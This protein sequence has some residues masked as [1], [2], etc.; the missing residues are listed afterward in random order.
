MIATRRLRLFCHI[1]RADLTEDHVPAL[2]ACVDHHP[3]TGNGLGV[4]LITRGRE[5]WN[6][7]SDHTTWSC[8]QRYSKPTT[9]INGGE[10]WIQLHPRRDL[11]PDQSIYVHLMMMMIEFDSLKLTTTVCA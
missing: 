5:W 8:G 7:I 6:R 11:P 10:S 2:S 3:K 1:A 9:E 4:V